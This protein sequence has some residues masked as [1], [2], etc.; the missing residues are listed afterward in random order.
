M[1]TLHALWDE[2]QHHLHLW[3]ERPPRPNPANSNPN[4]NSPRHPGARGHAALT[5]AIGALL[6]SSLAAHAKPAYRKLILPTLANAPLSSPELNLTPP[7]PTAEPITWQAWKIPTLAP[8]NPS[9]A[10]R[11]LAKNATAS[12]SS[13]SYNHSVCQQET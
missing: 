1:L 3:L 2:A 10:L 6:G 7:N 13:I 4:S 8:A 5:R 12:G 9:I 11:R